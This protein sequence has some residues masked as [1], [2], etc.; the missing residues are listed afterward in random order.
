MRRLFS[1]RLLVLVV[2]IVWALTGGPVLAVVEWALFA[3]LLWRAWPSVCSDV[4]R[5]LFA[6]RSRRRGK[7]AGGVL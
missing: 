7:T 1:W 5:L 6:G 3:Y 2:V 4:S